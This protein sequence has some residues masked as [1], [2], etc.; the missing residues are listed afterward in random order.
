MEERLRKFATLV[1]SGNFTRAAARLHTSQPALTVAVNKLE[2]ELG[3]QLV[4]RGARSF[5]LTPAG[6]VAY[7]SAKEII[8]TSM[9]LQTQLRD[10]AG[11]QPSATVGLIDSLASMLFTSPNSAGELASMSVI[12]NNSGYLLKAVAH[13]DIDVA[14]ITEQ[15]GQVSELLDVQPVGIEPMV[16]VAR[17]SQ[18]DA[19]GRQLNH[20]QPLQF[21][22]YDK[23]STTYKIIQTAL[24]ERGV[25]IA[26][27]F[28]SSSPEIM[29]ELVLRGTGVSVL[30]YFLVKDLLALGRLV[31]V[32]HPEIIVVERPISTI[33]RRRKKLPLALADIPLR[34][35]TMLAGQ[36]NLLKS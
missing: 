16:L 2:R 23:A 24:K 17:A 3:A 11:E 20:R 9:N 36:V 33:T 14:F 13:D 25:Q 4:V 30:P 6:E 31:V 35:E 34:I 32:K 18:K 26:P 1:E 27:I 12:V 21:I 5:E 19:I 8:L 15:P 7:R 29:R 22:S 10:L 28:Y